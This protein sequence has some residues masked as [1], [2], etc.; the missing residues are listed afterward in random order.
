MEFA[1]DNIVRDTKYTPN[2]RD[3]YELTLPLPN[4]EDKEKTLSIIKRFDAQKG[5]IEKSSSSKDYTR[6]QLLLA[7]SEFKF[8][9]ESC[10]N[11]IVE[12]Y[13][14][15][16]ELPDLAS[17]TECY[18]WLLNFLCNCDKEKY[19]EKKEG[20]HS[21]VLKDVKNSVDELL[22]TT[23][24]H[25]YI[26]RE[27]IKALV[28][29]DI[30]IALELIE[31]LNNLRDRDKAYLL[32]IKT[33]LNQF[34]K[35][36]DFELVTN[37]C[38]KI[39]SYKVKDE[40]LFQIVKKIT[41]IDKE[42]KPL[43]HIKDKESDILNL[44]DDIKS[45]PDKT[46][47]YA[48][49]YRYLI[50]LG[51]KEHNT[52]INNIIEKLDKSLNDI[53]IGWN[54][55]NITFKISKILSSIDKQLAK[56]YLGLADSLKTEVVIDSSNIATAYLGTLNLTVR[57]LSGL[58]KRNLVQ[59]TDIDRLSKLIDLIPS[60]GEKAIIWNEIALRC[61]INKKSD[62]CKEYTLNKIKP[63]LQSIPKDDL[64]YLYNI[65]VRCSPALYTANQTT[66][67][68]LLTTLPHSIEEDA[69]LRIVEFIL[70]KQSP[71]DPY[72]GLC[73]KGYILN[74]EE[75]VEI[76]DIIK[77]LTTDYYIYSMIRNVVDSLFDKRNSK[78][79]SIEQKKDICRRLKDLI[80]TK[81]PDKDN[82]KH[83]GY[84]IGAFALVF[85]IIK[86]DIKEWNKLIEQAKNIFNLADRAL[87]LSMIATAMPRSEQITIEE[88]IAEA[89]IIVENI[90]VDIDKTIL[91]F[92]LAEMV[93]EYDRIKTK[94]YLKKSLIFSINIE[95]TETISY[96]QKR[97]IDLA[98]RIDENFAT[99]LVSSIDDD[100]ARRY[101]K[102]NITNHL[103]TLATKKRMA[104][105]EEPRTF[106]KKEINNYPQAAWMNLGGLNSGEVL[107][108]HHNSMTTYLEAAANLPFSDSYPI[109]AYIIE[110][111]IRRLSD[112]DSAG[113]VL[114][115]IFQ[116]LLLDIE[117]FSYILRHSSGFINTT[118]FNVLDN[119]DSPGI[120]IGENEKEK[121]YK[122]IENW[123]TN[124]A[125]D[126]IKI[127][128]PYF[129]LNELDILSM[130][131]KIC[132]G[133]KV[134][135]L[136]SREQNI[137]V[138]Q[139]WDETYKTFWRDNI[140]L[141]DPPI[142]D[143]FIVGTEKKG[144]LP[145]HDRWIISKNSGLRLG[146]SLNALGL[147]KKTEIS[148]LNENEA[149]IHEQEIDEYLNRLKNTYKDEKL[150]YIMF[151][152]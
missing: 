94:E 50:C 42:N 9:E 49:L 112:T 136:T 117:L 93:Y 1:L 151:S 48:Y 41:N 22:K 75:A 149:H 95:D 52:L 14:F 102:L 28:N 80:E 79:I 4:I 132:S 62:I 43:V 134:F 34:Y 10:K 39:S 57:A 146:T 7:E 83:D 92:S 36:P 67:I 131:Q 76:C 140:T 147:G 81:L 17:K 56:K 45:L 65:Y 11:R 135:I 51:N 25:Y 20:L 122:Y 127:V 88:L 124:N 58:F 54:K 23:A 108:V 30:T 121:A 104:E 113:T 87:V 64:D 107:T 77:H 2:S 142:T 69:Y 150:K 37:I 60:K 128:D 73:N 31:S 97:I 110:N 15:I 101:H 143:I 29:A 99:T 119:Y 27:T 118:Q 53:D 6:F 24:K 85:K 114:L 96:Y 130:I 148:L 115:P 139:P 72:R 89:T 66:A 86:P 33:I 100:P 74:F 5:S 106:T 116:S 35:I 32:A 90:P 40:S 3:L 12:L 129:S 47:L 137:K 152:L 105:Q 8:D 13:L 71:S 109:Y 44:V 82:I 70:Y 21:L 63:L 138:P 55:I 125:K 144:I 141:Q 120:I 61:K 84:K 59:D 145:I 38:S 111:S 26:A 18:S 123:L 16:T 46:I 103:D 91:Y 133:I 126:Y 68:E 19:F 78:N 98:Y